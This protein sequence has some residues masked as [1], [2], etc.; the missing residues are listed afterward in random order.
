M[1]K[2]NSVGD[3]VAHLHVERLRG[4][5]GRGRQG[6]DDGLIRVLAFTMHD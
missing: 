3:W 4:N 5:G 6:V 1:N 2:D